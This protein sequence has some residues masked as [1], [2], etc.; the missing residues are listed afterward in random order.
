MMAVSIVTGITLDEFRAEVGVQ[1]SSDQS[2][3]D[4]KVL[5]RLFKMVCRVINDRTV[6]G[7]PTELK[8]QA[9]IMLGAYIHDRRLKTEG[10]F[11][12]SFPYAWTNSGCQWILKD[13]LQRPTALL[14]GV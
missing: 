7:T 14:E 4:Q 10:D 6:D 1:P 11:L 2:V 5:E 8:N 9:V 13:Y 3:L 12:P